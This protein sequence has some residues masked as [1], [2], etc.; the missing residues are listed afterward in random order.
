[1]CTSSRTHKSAERNVEAGV[2]YLHLMIERYLNDPGIEA[3]NRTL[4]A[5]AAY[6]A[7]PGNLN[8]FRRLAGKAGLDPN[9]WFQNVEVAGS[10]VV[11]RETVQYVAN[12]YKYYVAYRLVVERTEQRT[13]RQIEMNGK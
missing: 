6:N 9:V 2:K 10:R 1:M 4:M 3:K 13:A 12:I 8:K 11:G 7:G 5:F